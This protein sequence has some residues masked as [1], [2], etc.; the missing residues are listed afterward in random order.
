MCREVKDSPITMFPFHADLKDY[1]LFKALETL[2]YS[3]INY[4]FCSRKNVIIK[5]VVA[6]QLAILH[7]FDGDLLGRIVF[8][9][10]K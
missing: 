3:N 10:L 2:N 4:K 7:C 9:N 1:I 6:R 5:V 8:P